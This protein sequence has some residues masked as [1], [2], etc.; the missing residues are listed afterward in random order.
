MGS[1][2]IFTN[3]RHNFKFQYMNRVSIHIK[4]VLKDIYPP[5]EIKSL[6]MIIWCDLLGKKAIDIYLER[7]VNLSVSENEL[8]ENTLQRMLCFEP[9]QY[10]LGTTQ[11]CNHS[12]Q[13]GPGALIPRPETQEL[14]ELIVKENTST[15]PTILDIGTGSGCIAI[16]LSL[17]LPEAHVYAWDVSND[18]L[19][20]ACSNNKEL[21]AKVNFEQCDV[22][23]DIEY[24]NLTAFDVIVSNPPYITQSEKV[25][26]DHHV[27]DWEPDLALFVED[28]D[29]L[30]FYRRIAEHGKQ[31]L[32]K[33]GQLYYEIN[34]AYG[35]E[36]VQM[37]QE[38]GYTDCRVLK[39][40]YGNDRIVTGCK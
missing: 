16:S 31:L 8:L 29:P 3:L 17:A 20:I 9:I 13:V 27:L 21:N 19:A 2:A 10:I 32:K 6:V 12:F 37:L 30:L 35:L 34:R 14:V 18:A 7:D 1:N 5:E 23:S 39:D 22:L 33:G 38:L 36:T 28:H 4:E 25:D 24:N 26:M 15:S 11:F 40:F